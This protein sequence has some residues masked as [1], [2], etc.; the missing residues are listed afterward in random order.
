M[1]KIKIKNGVRIL[2]IFYDNN[3][4]KVAIIAALLGA[5]GSLLFIGKMIYC[6]HSENTGFTTDDWIGL[7]ACMLIF[8][9][10]YL[11]HLL[12]MLLMSLCR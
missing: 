3:G 6:E 5:V 1:D 11:F 9:M 12:G 4:W 10:F 2:P 7:S 8:A